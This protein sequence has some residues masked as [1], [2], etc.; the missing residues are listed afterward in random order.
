MKYTTSQKQELV[1]RYQNGESVSDICTQTGIARS[2]LY[3]W[4][5]PYQT[6]ITEAGTVVTPQE[7]S[8]LKKRVEKLEGIIQVLKSVDCTV[9]APLQ[10]KLKALE[11][12]YGQFSVHTLCDALEVPRG[13][14]YNHIFRN[15]KENKSYQLRRT[16]LSEQIRQIYDESDQIYGAKK[17]SA[18]LKSRGVATSDK[19]VSELMQEMNLASIRTGA[20]RLYMRFHA[21]KKTD[22]LGKQ[23]SVSAPNQIWVSDVT[24]FAYNKKMYYICAIL[25]LYSRKVISYKISQ[26]HSSQLITSTFRSA[27][28]DRRPAE[29]LIFHSDRGTQYTGFAFQKLRKTLRV[30]QSFSPSGKPCHNAVME[31]FFAS[32]KREELYRRN[33]HSV[34]ELKECVRKYMDFYNMERPHSTLGYRAPNTYEAL[35]YDRQAV[36][37][38]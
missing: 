16:E 22:R 32:L 34:E 8:A 14:F 35:Y 20:K 23:F 29:G 9:S 36:K 15:K 1:L 5:K 27:Y 11:T 18:V 38:K 26:K 17:I 31:S 2:T 6:T 33:Y 24:Y 7:F 28:E 30:E 21:Q 19:M 3:S 10:D 13:T 4:L 25:D 12:L 37:E